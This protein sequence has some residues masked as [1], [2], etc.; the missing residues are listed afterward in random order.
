MAYILHIDTSGNEGTVFLAADG[1]PV[2]SEVNSNSRD[3]A[4]SI[5]LM[6]DKVLAQ[7][8]ITL[9]QLDAVAVCG[10]P[11]SY[12]GLRIGLATAKGYCYAADKSL[13]LHSKLELLAW[14][15]Y[16]LL[17]ENGKIGQYNGIAAALIARPGEYFYA[18]Y[19]PHFQVVDAPQHLVEEEL[20]ALYGRNN[21]NMYLTGEIALNFEEILKKH[22]L[23][24]YANNVLLQQ[25]AWALYSFNKFNCQDFV[26]LQFSEP[27][28]L[29]HVHIAK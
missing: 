16:T 14:Q 23:I 18:S 9:S 15:A 19:D 1:I 28:Y 2:A 10:G 4:A 20:T 22:G 12:T 24:T 8:G 11:G 27:F 25:A 7:A 5:N 6:T 13:M 29:K 21:Y 3:H 26:S 17:S